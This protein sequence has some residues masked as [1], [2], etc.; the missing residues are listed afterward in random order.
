MT[1]AKFKITRAYIVEAK[2]KAEARQILASDPEQFLE[3]ESIK[4]LPSS[5]NGW[6]AAV[7]KQ[8]TGKA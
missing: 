6:V 3:W 8:L 1:M 2:T 4:E 5:G 7:T